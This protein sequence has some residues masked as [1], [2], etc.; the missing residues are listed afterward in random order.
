[1]ANTL[2]R[3]DPFNEMARFDPFRSIDEIFRD[4]SVG[5]SS[6]R[7]VEAAPRIR[8]DVSETDQEYQVRADLPGV[9][10]SDIKVA[11]ENNQVSISAE[12]KEE[13]DARTTGMI[14]SERY[15]G[16]QYR[17]FALPQDIDDSKAQARYEN[18]VLQLMLPKKAGAASKQITIQ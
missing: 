12:T 2:M 10:K 17:S 1:M 8:L 15:Y 11:I 13:R 4:F 5:P 3:F 16:Q 14:R 7:G 18:G 9:K 6:W